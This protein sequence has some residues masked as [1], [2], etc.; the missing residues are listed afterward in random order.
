MCSRPS[1]SAL[2]ILGAGIS[3]LSL[4]FADGA[5][6]RRQRAG[7]LARRAEMARTLQLTDLCVT[8]EARYT[9]HPSQAD[10]QSMFQDHPL[11]LEHFPSGSVLAPPPTLTTPHA[12]LDRKTEIPD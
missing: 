8:S 6:L 7:A 2:I 10:L 4:T 12:D 3:L 9:R 11:S 1:N 5:L